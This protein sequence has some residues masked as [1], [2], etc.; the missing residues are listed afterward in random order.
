MKLKIFAH[1]GLISKDIKENSLQAFNN[2]Y[3]SGFKAIELDIWYLE[4]QLILTHDKPKDLKN[5]DKLED[6][7]LK[8]KNNIEYWLDFKNLDDKNCNFALRNLKT[9]IDKYK[10]NLQNLYFTPFITDF[11]KANNIYNMIRKYFGKNVQIV[12]VAEILPPENYKK[13]YTKLKENNIFGL[14]VEYKNINQN[15][16]DV[17]CDIKIFAWTV[18]DKKSAKLLNKIGIENITSDKLTPNLN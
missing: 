14:S 15:F 7:F 1:R 3:K 11:D 13:Y 17:F 9:I 16:R 5:L 8:F 2:A 10:I 4:N 12:A 18:N 6:L